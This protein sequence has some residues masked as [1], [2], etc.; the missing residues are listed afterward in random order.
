ME[1]HPLP[2]LYGAVSLGEKM[3]ELTVWFNERTLDL[4]IVFIDSFEFEI[5]PG[6]RFHFTVQNIFVEGET[7][8]WKSEISRFKN[9]GWVKIGGL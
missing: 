3:R 1:L 6:G 4:A 2:E 9:N 7:L 8:Y 5:L